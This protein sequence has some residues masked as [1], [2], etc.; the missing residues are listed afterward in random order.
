MTMSF[1][2]QTRTFRVPED[3][4]DD[5]YSLIYVTQDEDGD[6][7]IGFG[8]ELEF[9]LCLGCDNDEPTIARLGFPTT[10]PSVEPTPTETLVEV[11]V[12]ND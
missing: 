7:Q 3:T 12:D 6:V 5:R 9:L 10:P 1:I 4:S 2:P 11:E 8:P